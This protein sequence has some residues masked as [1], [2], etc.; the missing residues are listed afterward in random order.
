MVR[1]SIHREPYVDVEH[2]SPRSYVIAARPA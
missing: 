2:P 1:A